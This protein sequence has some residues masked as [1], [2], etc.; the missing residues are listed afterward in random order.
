MTLIRSLLGG[1]APKEHL[2][3][4]IHKYAVGQSV[5]LA[6]GHGFR[7]VVSG[8]YRVLELM[9][10]REESPVYRIRSPEELFERTAREYELCDAF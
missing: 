3:G 6:P 1:A 7:G 10:C 5:I 9:P 8:R 2:S 4:A